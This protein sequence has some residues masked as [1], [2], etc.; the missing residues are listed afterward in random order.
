MIIH[1]SSIFPFLYPSFTFFPFFL[2]SL[3]CPSF[4]LKI[5]FLSFFPFNHIFFPFFIV[6]Y[7]SLVILVRAIFDSFFLFFTFD[8]ALQFLL[9][10]I[11]NHQH[12]IQIFEVSISVKFFLDKLSYTFLEINNYLISVNFSI[13]SRFIGVDKI[14]F[15]VKLHKS[16]TSGDTFTISYDSNRFNDSVFLSI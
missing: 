14:A 12:L 1:L 2:F 6:F 3:F 9:Q 13:I 8:Q 10:L 16:I 15:A 4:P 5:S 7:F 11:V